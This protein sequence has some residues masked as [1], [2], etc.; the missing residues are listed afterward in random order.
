MLYTLVEPYALV[1]AKVRLFLMGKC[2]RA[3]LTRGDSHTSLRSLPGLIAIYNLLARV[4][5]KYRVLVRDTLGFIISDVEE[6]ALRSATF[7]SHA[8]PLDQITIN[9]LVLFR[10]RAVA[11]LWTPLPPVCSMPPVGV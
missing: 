9:I 3:Q 11:A 4:L 5:L 8:I 10:Q 6:Q 7:Q 2:V 1:Q